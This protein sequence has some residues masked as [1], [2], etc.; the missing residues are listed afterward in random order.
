MSDAGAS[1]ERETRLSA[2]RQTALGV[3]CTKSALGPH[4][5][6]TLTRATY[7]MYLEAPPEVIE[8]MG[9]E[10]L[11]FDFGHALSAFGAPA[12]L[13]VGSEDAKTPPKLTRELANELPDAS[14]V[15]LAGVGHMT[16]LEA[17]DAITD[18]ILTP[19]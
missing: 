8:H 4:A 7:D 15:E 17:P 18:A 3:V 14:V 12:T 13:L 16:P 19:R 11:T 6:Y 10:L 1:I 5:G 2:G 9:R